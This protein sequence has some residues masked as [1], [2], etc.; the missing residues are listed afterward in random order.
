MS[1]VELIRTTELNA[2]ER[3]LWASFRASQSDLVSP[4]FS[5]RWTF[6][7]AKVRDDVR[8]AVLMSD[9]AKIT[10][11]LPLQKP[12][13]QVAIAVGGAL[14]DYHGI[15]AEPSL[16]LNLAQVMR[17]IKVGRYDFSHVP[18]SQSNFARFA[19]INHDSHVID[20]SG[21]LDVY[22]QKRRQRGS[23]ET[24][25]ARKRARKLSKDLG[26]IRLES[27]STDQSVFD[28][29]LKWKRAQYQHTQTPD[30]FE[31][32]W[33]RNLVQNLFELGQ[34]GEF[35]GAL[36]ALYAGDQLVA[37]NYC[38]ADGGVL[39]AWFIAHNP[40]FSRYS[41][42]QVLFET[43]IEQLA[44]SHIREI[45]LGAGDYRFKSSLASFGRPL[46]VGFVGGSALSSLVRSSEY[47]LRQWIEA[48][49]LG[50]LSQLPGKAMR[51]FDV[52]RGLT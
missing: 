46:N 22:L 7:V 44:D 9:R 42:G 28:Q 26:A 10:G 48:M 45:D 11:F 25:R 50:K 5:S 8:V 31:A 40:V 16:Q 52:Y 27:W 13:G 36:F 41:P 1:K 23:S 2:N 21:G 47:Q 15:I 4:Y 35:G 33:T 19:Q 49:P 12:R 34:L 32:K 3:A 37:A 14:S 6:E 29:L 18:A 43:M 17:Q 30:V 24:K 39:H 20:L 51:R 38:L